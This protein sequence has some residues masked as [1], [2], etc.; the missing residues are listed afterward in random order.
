MNRVLRLAAAGISLSLVCGCG[1]L[2]TKV[3]P[4]QHQYSL[5]GQNNP[6]NLAATR[7][8]APASGMTLIVSPPHAAAGFDSPRMMYV[9][10]EGKLEYFAYNEWI[11]T[12]AR[13]LSPLI[14]AA[15]Q[16]SGAFRAVVERPTTAAGDLRLDTEILRLQQEFLSKP[17]QVRFTLRAYIVESSTRRVVATRD[18]EAIVPADSENPHG[19]VLAANRAVQAVLAQLTDFC[20]QAAGTAIAVTAADSKTAR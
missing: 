14:I 18:F 11:D 6:V 13:M 10:Q 4:S 17:S 15:L 12:P 7:P 19:G 3:S 5:G 16:G 2:D 8:R 1:L 20:A 9:R